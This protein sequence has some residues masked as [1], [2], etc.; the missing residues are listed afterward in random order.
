MTE[1][2]L[3]FDF[4]EGDPFPVLSFGPLHG[5]SP[6]DMVFQG[7]EKLFHLP[8]FLIVYQNPRRLDTR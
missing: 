3:L 4:L 6:E 5:L 2:Q 8:E 7:L 1:S